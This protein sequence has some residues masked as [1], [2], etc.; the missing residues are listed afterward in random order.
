MIETK[1]FTSL[2]YLGIILANTVWRIIFLCAR[3]VSLFCM[4]GPV[5]MKRAL[6]FLVLV[7]CFS[8][9]GIFLVE[10]GLV[11]LEIIAESE[12]LWT[13]VA[14]SQRK[15]IFVNFPN[16]SAEHGISVAEISATG[17]LLPYPDEEW[18]FWDPDL[19]PSEHFI[20]VQSVY[21]DKEDSLWILD[22]ASPG[23]D[24]VV[25]GGPKLV[26]IDLNT[27]RISRRYFFDLSAAPL[28]SYLND[29]RIDDHRGFAY[30]TDSGTGALIVLDLQSG[31]SRRILED[32]PSTKAE[33]ITLVI[34]GNEFASHIHVDGLALD[35][36][37]E[38]LYYQALSGR[39]LY[40]VPTGVLR[41]FSVSS[42]TI[43]R[44]VQKLGVTGA[45]DGIEFGMD[46][47]LY[48]SSIE[49]NAIRSYD[50]ATG[51]TEVVAWG[52]MIKWP[53]SFSAA[54]D[55]YIYFTV[56]QLHQDNPDEP[57]RILRFKP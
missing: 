20:C 28:K 3:G 4:R 34:E 24:G 2:V 22:P 40:R 27:S 12:K 35:A 5:L 31:K 39:T 44:S 57:Y 23:L 8:T 51:K 25:E 1:D 37:G 15:R 55:G 19:S 56:S 54:A 38:Y 21:V 32:H 49:S 14:V 43:G 13:G 18:N 9:F 11:Q 10:A 52:S 29:V 53:D 41:D 46:G 7:M 16:W 45:S 17:D 30:I 42:E 33:D 47:L 48:L 6:L 50:P 36:E 26:K